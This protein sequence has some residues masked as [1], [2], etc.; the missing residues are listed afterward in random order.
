[1]EEVKIEEDENRFIFQF[2]T[3]GSLTAKETLKYA[4]KRLRTRLDKIRDSVV[5]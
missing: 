1:M 2:E 4:I 5:V 3:D